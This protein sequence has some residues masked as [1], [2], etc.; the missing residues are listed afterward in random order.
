MRHRVNR[1]TEDDYHAML[2]EAF[3]T[4]VYRPTVVSAVVGPGAMLR[5]SPG[6]DIEF[7]DSRTIPRNRTCSYCRGV[8]EGSVSECPGCGARAWT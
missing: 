7:H 2:M 1:M 5:V 3:N 6:E 4:E 8:S